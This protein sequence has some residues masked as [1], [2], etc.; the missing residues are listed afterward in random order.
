MALGLEKKIIPKPDSLG[1]LLKSLFGR[2][3]INWLPTECS[4]GTWHSA[5]YT[6]HRE[7]DGAETP[8]GRVHLIFLRASDTTAL[9]L[10]ACTLLLP[11]SLRGFLSQPHLKIIAGEIRV[12]RQRHSSYKERCFSFI[13]T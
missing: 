5:R 6:A 1:D 10:H 11:T 3:C 9:P 4:P 7:G 13:D 2:M 12:M 8:T